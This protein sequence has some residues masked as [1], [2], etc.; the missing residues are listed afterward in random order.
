V[1]EMAPRGAPGP[2]FGPS[3]NGGK[4]VNVPPK[5]GGH[6]QGGARFE[7]GLTEIRK[8]HLRQDSM[9]CGDSPLQRKAV[10]QGKTARCLGRFPPD[11]FTTPIPPWHVLVDF[12]SRPYCPPERLNFRRQ[13][14]SDA[15]R[16]P[17]FPCGAVPP[18]PDRA[19]P[20][21]GPDSP[22]GIL[23]PTMGTENRTGGRNFP[24][25][26]NLPA[27]GNF[28]PYIRRG[29]LEGRPAR[30]YCRANRQPACRP[31]KAEK[32]FHPGPA[33]RK[34]DTV[35]PQPPRPAR[36]L[37]PL[38]RSGN[39]AGN[40][41]TAKKKPP[42]SWRTPSRERRDRPPALHPDDFFLIDA[43]TPELCPRSDAVALIA[44]NFAQ[45]MATRPPATRPR[46]SRS[47][48]QNPRPR[49]SC[50]G[51]NRVILVRAP[52]RALCADSRRW[53]GG[54]AR[55]SPL[56]A[57]RP[58]GW[59]F[60]PTPPH[61]TVQPLERVGPTQTPRCGWPYFEWRRPPGEWGGGRRA[62]AAL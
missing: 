25:M 28:R 1:A 9:L 58:K 40:P 59:K 45:K 39:L 30:L 21:R 2:R 35:V 14:G 41:V 5:P 34:D 38:W 20:R 53:A 57:P 13:R 10:K 32:R 62:L 6:N 37:G 22:I 54:V 12:P 44:W 55:A 3:S 18:F 61:L 16:S 4:C 29:P 27:S 8:N 48:R 52:V 42:C 31:P 26:H 46:A 60:G 15:P 43:E 49:L 47:F 11:Q 51:R 19:R 17:R 23:P 7:N 33:R 50:P 56:I 24:H 36:V